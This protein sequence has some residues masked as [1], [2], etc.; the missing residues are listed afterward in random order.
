LSVLKR[1]ADIGGGYGIA[2]L[3]TKG[4]FWYKKIKDIK[5]LIG[6]KMEKKK[7]KNIETEPT[8]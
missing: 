7:A 8:T 4:W 3:S 6:Y 5:S 2:G 1:A